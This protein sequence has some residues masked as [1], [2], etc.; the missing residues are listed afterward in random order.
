[1][2]ELLHR[3]ATLSRGNLPDQ[4]DDDQ[5]APSKDAASQLAE[6]DGWASRKFVAFLVAAGLIVAVDLLSSIHAL[7]ALAGNLGTVVGGL[8][9]L[10]GA[11]AGANV[12]MKYAAA[13]VAKAQI[14]ADSAAD[15]A[16]TPA[17]PA[18][19]KK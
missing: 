2:P 5:P 11:F 17:P 10:Y 4:M 14:T 19:P 13:G 9:T 8:V 12:A 16:P 3:N 6:D 1:M 18:K 7:S 15:A